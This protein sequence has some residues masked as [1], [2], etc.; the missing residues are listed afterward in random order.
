MADVWPLAPLQ[1]GMVADS[2]LTGDPG[3]NV[4]QI[5]CILK[6]PIDPERFRQSWIRTAADFDALRLRFTL[7]NG[8]PRQRVDPSP[9]VPFAVLDWTASGSSASRRRLLDGFLEDDRAHG[10]DLFAAPLLRVTLIFV[11]G[12][13]RIFVWTLHHAMIDGGSY[14]AVLERVFDHYEGRPIDGDPAPQYAQFLEW[15]SRHETGPGREFFR[16][17]LGG[18]SGPT[19]LPLPSRADPGRAGRTGEVVQRLGAESTRALTELAKSGGASLNTVVQLVWG[20]LLARCTDRDDVVFG[21]AWAG[22]RQTIDRADRTV[23]IFLNTLPVRVD[24]SAG[25]TVR[26]ALHTLR[27]QH[28]EIRPHLQTPLSAIKVV[29]DMRGGGHLFDTIVVFWYERYFSTL[30]RRN[31]AWTRRELWSRSRT[32][33]LLGLAAYL[34]AGSL[35]IQ[36]EYRVDVYDASRATELLS[37][38]MRLLESVARDPSQCVHDLHMLDDETYVALTRHETERERPPAREPVVSRIRRV[39]AAQPTAVAVQ[40][41]DGAG[42][43]YGEL[44]ERTRA[45]AAELRARGLRPGDIA[46]IYLPHS[47]DAV[48]S[49]LAVHEAGG[50][51]LPLDP[52]E[53]SGRTRYVLD[54]AHARWLLT[55]AVRASGVP[56]GS[57][58]LV[59][60]DGPLEPA[61]QAVEMPDLGA[62]SPAYV[63]YTSGSTGMPKGACISHGALAHHADAVASVFAL[64]AADRAL[65]M[66]AL[67]FDVALEEIFPTLACGAAVVVRAEGVTASVRDF[68]D[69]V[70]RSRLTVLNLP[71]AFWHE[72]AAASPPLEWPRCV[73]LVIVGGERVSRLDHA[74]FRSADTGHIRLLNGYGMT[75]ATITSTCYDDA[76]GDH[77]SDDVPIGRPIPGVSHFLLDRHCRPVPPSG[78]GQLFIGGAGV[79]LGYLGRPA[80]TAERFVPHPWR[81]G[82]RLYATGD[83]VRRTARGNYVYVDRA[84]DQV[85]VRGFRIEP[86]EIEALLRTHP[87][88][89]EAAVVVCRRETGEARLVGYASGDEEKLTPASVREHLER[90]LPSHMV[91]SSLIVEPRLPR[92]RAGKI[93]RAALAA[94]D[95]F[96]QPLV[97][98]TAELGVAGTFGDAGGLERELMTLWSDLLRVSVAQRSVS[99]FELGGDS[100]LAVRLFCEVEERFGSRCDAQAFFRSPTVDTLAQLIRKGGGLDWSAPVVC[101]A[102]GSPGVRPLFLAPGIT[103]RAADYLHLAAAMDDDVPVHAI[104]AGRPPKDEGA[105]EDVV[106]LVRGYVESMRT[107]QARGPYALA[108]FSAGGTISVAMAEALYEEGDAVDFLGLL[109]AA[110]PASV[111]VVSPFTSPKRFW[112]LSKTTVGRIREVL[113]GPL[114]P[115]RLWRRASS[116]A[117]RSVGRWFS[118]SGETQYEVSDVLGSPAGLGVEDAARMQARLDA[119]L[120]YKPKG[121]PI[122]VT[123]FRTA[124][125]PFEGP[126][127][128]DLGWGRA[129]RGRIEIVPI[130]GRHFEVLSAKGAAPLARALGRR[131][132]RC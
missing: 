6:E 58:E 84:D 130:P 38:Y 71:T 128:P 26:E 105:Q 132:P 114:V 48:V 83:I 54:D 70:K 7:Q 122:D 113:E 8:E 37:Y 107:V 92:T 60:V 117:R 106:S 98:P 16:K 64:T 50:A 56:G 27:R 85:K 53:P 125:D 95:A 25:P 89:A 28:L 91:P 109:D 51:F 57:F 2:I 45:L 87:E 59:R 119:I 10:F 94:R 82:A 49:M 116:A 108:G 61:P 5:V 35:V 22:R 101:L 90:W 96:P 112:R 40:Q 78:E 111:P 79:G 24:L 33:Y 15:F 73:R 3:L 100:L 30:R 66:A 93:D 74:K 9:E 29:S 62:E 118:A 23:G 115:P 14:E 99:F 47:I 69:A 1:Q 41:M 76:E 97:G 42:I 63:I 102:P 131:V 13:E 19:K 129:L 17:L 126:H 104:Q 75:E 18:F 123:L 36:L 39:A 88:V 55:D 4:E 67:G 86:G 80:L 110:P 65:Q 21:A 52:N 124:L 11:G 72:L 31:D 121:Y 127:E 81:A 43:T 32:G 68:F 34:D 12:G 46:A 120:W 103:G 20:L 77:D 44:A